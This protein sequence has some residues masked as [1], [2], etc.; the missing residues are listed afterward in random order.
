MSRKSLLVAVPLLLLSGLADAF[1]PTATPEFS[2]R[3]ALVKSAY[4]PSSERMAR[5]SAASAAS[6][7]AAALPAVGL[8]GK[9]QFR[10]F[11]SAWTRFHYSVAT[12]NIDALRAV[13]RNG[14]SCR[15]ALAVRAEQLMESRATMWSPAG[16]AEKTMG[17]WILAFG[18]RI[19]AE[20][21]GAS[22]APFL[23]A[24]GPTTRVR[25]GNVTFIEGEYGFWNVDL[26]C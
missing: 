22:E 2:K 14:R 1:E 25:F 15:N 16:E 10:M 9:E 3:R 18:Q 13:V 11:N 6:A 7:S 4:Q 8:L 12:G 21:L 23:V 19:A 24:A 17:E 26:G 5:S 20:Q